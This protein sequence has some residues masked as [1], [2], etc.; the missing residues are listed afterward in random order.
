MTNG[1]VPLLGCSSLK[2]EVDEDETEKYMR[3]LAGNTRGS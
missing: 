3:W 1:W 2:I